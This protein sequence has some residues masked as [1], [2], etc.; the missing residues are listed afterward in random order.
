MANNAGHKARRYYQWLLHVRH[1]TVAVTKTP[2]NKGS[3]R[4]SPSARPGCGVTKK[5]R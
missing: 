5:A 4:F 2:H 1:P 3:L